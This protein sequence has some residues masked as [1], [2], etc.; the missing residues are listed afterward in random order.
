VVIIYI[1][2]KKRPPVIFLL[3]F[4]TVSNKRMEK[5][6]VLAKSLKENPVRIGD[7]PAAVIGDEGRNYTTVCF[8]QVGR[9]GY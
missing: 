1:G 9:R 2:L 3:T 4:L 5:V 7:G 6:Q 8:K